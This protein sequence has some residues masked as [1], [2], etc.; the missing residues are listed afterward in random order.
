VHILKSMLHF[1]L[2]AGLLVRDFVININI[3]I[4]SARKGADKY[5]EKEMIAFSGV[6]RG[7]EGVLEPPHYARNFLFN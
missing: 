3:N 1:S 4:N 6:A 5:Q 7:V 2:H